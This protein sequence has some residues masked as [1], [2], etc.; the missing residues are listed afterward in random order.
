MPKIQ[1]QQSVPT[2]LAEAPKST[3]DL[4]PIATQHSVQV[5]NLPKPEVPAS[6]TTI[7]Q[8]SSQGAKPRLSEIPLHIT[9]QGL[10]L[11]QTGII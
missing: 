7:A 6:Q 5:S 11:I 2:A 3:V 10:V 8:N 4:N 9:D 1:G